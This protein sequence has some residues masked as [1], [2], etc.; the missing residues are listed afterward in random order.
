M[1]TL[2]ITSGMACK[3]QIGSDEIS[4]LVVTGGHAYD[5]VEF[6]EMFENLPGISFESVEKPEAWKM[7]S[8]G[9]VY[10]AIAF[11]D[12]WQEISEDEKKIFL[13]EFERGT[14]MVFLHH[15]L[16]SHQEW[17]EY[18]QLVGGKYNQP[19]ST[20]DTSQLSHYKHDILIKVSV[21]DKSHPVT[22]G[23]ADFEILD[24]GYSNTIQL[25]GI[26]HLLET[27]HPDS[28]RYIGWTHYYNNSK[29][30]YLMGGHNK[31]AYENPS[32]RKLLSN[33]I[34]WTAS[35]D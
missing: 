11:Y 24:E 10:D 27:S 22:S 31:H 4:L 18:I 13:N 26:H 12:M 1:F 30:V 35:R 19:E 21:L 3:N 15:S 28:D 9:Y 17:P 7:L 29:V 34:R 32:F 2:F 25:P 23:M 20:S 8:S 16:V 6:I 5:T 33:A 14:G